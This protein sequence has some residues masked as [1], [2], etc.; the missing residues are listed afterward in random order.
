MASNDLRVKKRDVIL[1]IVAE[2]VA[3]FDLAEMSKIA[4][5]VDISFAPVSR[6]KHLADDP[7]LNQGGHMVEID[8]PNGTS[9]RVPGLPLEMGEHVFGVRRQTPQPGQHTR[10]VLLE[11]G[12]SANDIDLLMAQGAIVCGDSV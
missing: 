10:E 12:Y 5:D 7:H 11:A 9:S 3:R 4:E 1:P 6:P 8:F 2:I